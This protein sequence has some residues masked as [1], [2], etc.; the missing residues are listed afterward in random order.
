M[1]EYCTTRA[2]WS[3][4]TVNPMGEMYIH[5]SSISSLPGYECTGNYHIDPKQCSCQGNVLSRYKPHSLQGDSASKRGYWLAWTLV[6]VVLGRQSQ[7][8][9][10]GSRNCCVNLYLMSR[11][12]RR[13]LQRAVHSRLYVYFIPVST[14]AAGLRLWL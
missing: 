7:Y 11:I 6:D 5:T 4:V 1:Q 13:N 9:R 12:S 2:R 3:P 14:S 10:D 8:G